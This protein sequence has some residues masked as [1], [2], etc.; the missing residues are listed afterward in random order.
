MSTAVASLHNPRAGL[1]TPARSS[2]RSE[3]ANKL[4]EFRERIRQHLLDSISVRRSA[5]AALDELD[6]VRAEA[7]SSG[8]D[9]YS[10]NPINLASYRKARTFLEAIPTTSPFPEVS[11]AGDGDV[12]LDWFFGPRQAVTLS[13]AGDGRITFAW[14]N[15]HCSYRGTDW[16][17]EGIPANIAHAISQ[18]ARQ[19][20]GSPR[21]A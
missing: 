15:G 14:V 3:S 12:T 16:F 13:I 4:V 10:A 17:D 1:I 20:E 18:L 8:W 9:G 2:G 11:V 6:Q 7:S 21:T 19:A 5:E